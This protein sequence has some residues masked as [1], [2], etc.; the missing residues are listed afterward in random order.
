MD[1]DDALNVGVDF[2][3]KDHQQAAVIIKH[4]KSAE[5]K[6][7]G[8][9]LAQFINH[10]EEHFAREEDMMQAVNFFAYQPHKAEHTRVLDE[11]NAA[12]GHVKSGMTDIT[13]PV[14]AE[15][16]EDWLRNHRNTM[17]QVTAGFA[18]ENGYKSP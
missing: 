1:W 15:R 18:L 9:L 4:L 13:G 14:L 7:V 2:M 11:L 8:D 5:G 10:S 12:L 6:D 17:D 3:D 16:L